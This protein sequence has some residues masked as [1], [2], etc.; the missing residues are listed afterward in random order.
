M[1]GSQRV[2]QSTSEEEG[3]R[4]EGTVVTVEK[5]QFRLL[6]YALDRLQTR[7]RASSR[8]GRE[9]VVGERRLGCARF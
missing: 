8:D 7:H 6:N 9:N 4:T 2:P 3:H 5:M 1:T